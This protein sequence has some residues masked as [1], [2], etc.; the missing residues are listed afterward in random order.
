M[1]WIQRDVYKT[2]R[3]VS[4]VTL[5]A[6]MMAV[7]GCHPHDVAVGD[8]H[9]NQ[10]SVASSGVQRADVMVGVVGLADATTDKLLLDAYAGQGLKASYVSTRDTDDP[11]QTAQQGVKDLVDRVVSAIV[12]VGLDATVDEQGWNEALQKARDGGIP[13]ILVEPLH[14]PSDERLYAATFTIRDG[15]IN[16]AALDKG[17]MSVINDASHSRQ[18]TISASS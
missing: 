15:S 3:T 6:L 18:I 13:V 17:T 4:A 10:S 16:A 9:S 2:L 11:N 1:L 12:I 7:A 8:T 5:A 14:A